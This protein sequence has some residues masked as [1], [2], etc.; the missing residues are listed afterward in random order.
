MDTQR[1]FTQVYARTVENR[2]QSNVTET[3]YAAIQ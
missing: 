1:P 3:S 2:N